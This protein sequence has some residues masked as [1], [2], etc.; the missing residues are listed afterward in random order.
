MRAFILN[1]LPVGVAANTDEQRSETYGYDVIRVVYSL[2]NDTPVVINGVDYRLHFISAEVR[3]SKDGTS[4]VAYVSTDP[5][6]HRANWNGEVTYA[7]RRKVTNA[8]KDL[9][10]TLVASGHIDMLR[11]QGDRRILKSQITRAKLDISKAEKEL[12]DKLAKL[13]QLEAELG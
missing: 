12:A 6:M 13:E 2:D 10:E 5:G 3:I 1:D 11:K 9:T 4:T 7:A 8:I